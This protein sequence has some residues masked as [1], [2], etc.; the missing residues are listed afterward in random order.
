MLFGKKKS[1]AQ[2]RPDDALVR[3]L[4]TL[5]IN[6]ILQSRI[7]VGGMQSVRHGLWDIAT[8]YADKL[9]EL[10]ADGDTVLPKGHL[11]VGYKGFDRLETT[12]TDLIDAI[13]RQKDEN[14][15]A[16]GMLQRIQAN[17][18]KIKA[19]L[20]GDSDEARNEVDKANLAERLA[21]DL[22]DIKLEQQQYVTLRKIWEI[23]TDEVAMQTVIDLDGDVTTRVQPRFADAS[24]TTL[25]QLH[26]SAVDLSFQHWKTLINLLGELLSSV[27]GALFKKGPKT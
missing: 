25:H 14:M 18:S 15:A 9:I 17:S 24:S 21:K 22:A 16:I 4:L 12:A 20:Q 7:R 5:Q 26:G 3:D 8:A 23:G 2:V 11:A 13:D 6:T 1:E 19:M 27:M 10:G